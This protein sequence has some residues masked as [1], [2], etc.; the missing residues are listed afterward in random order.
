V[1]VL[2]S[3]TR[4]TMTIPI[5]RRIDLAPDAELLQ[6]RPPVPAQPV[7]EERLAS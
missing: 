3:I 2:A 4:T 5:L 7:V 6:L 1:L